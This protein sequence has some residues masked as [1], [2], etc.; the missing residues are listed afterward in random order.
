MLYTETEGH[1][2]GPRTFPCSHPQTRGHFQRPP[3]NP[4]Y[5]DRHTH[6][7]THTHR[8]S[9]SWGHPFP[10]PTPPRRDPRALKK[11][12]PSTWS[13]PWR[14]ASGPPGP[15][16]QTHTHHNPSLSLHNINT[17]PRVHTL[18]HTRSP[19]QLPP[20]RRLAA[21]APP[22][23]P[24]RCRPATPHTRTHAP[25]LPSP[26]ASPKPTARARALPSAVAHPRA[27]PPGTR[28]QGPRP[29]R[30]RGEEGGGGG[31]GRGAGSGRSYLS[32]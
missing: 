27:P 4:T 26:N 24:K 3:L 15:H 31:R 32:S 23:A 18:D 14:S 28:S 10:L 11:N 12:L 30:P 25:P 8:Q 19:G 7:H 9:A 21:S 29:A 17:S 13:L 16:R 6:T 1:F 20:P 22:S 5:I 2:W